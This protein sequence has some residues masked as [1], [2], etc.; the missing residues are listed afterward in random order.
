MEAK[1]PL[2]LSGHTGTGKLTL[3]RKVLSDVGIHQVVHVDVHHML[4]KK[5]DMMVSCTLSYQ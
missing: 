2:I 4:E 5:D 3:V 1:E